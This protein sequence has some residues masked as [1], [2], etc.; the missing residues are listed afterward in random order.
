[1]CYFPDY[2]LVRNATAAQEQQLN[3]S[4][5]ASGTYILTSHPSRC[6][7]LGILVDSCFEQRI[8]PGRSDFANRYR[9]FVHQ[10]RD[11]SMSQYEII[12]SRATISSNENVN[13]TCD[14]S[15]AKWIVEKGDNIAV[16][17]NACDDNYNNCPAHGIFDSLQLSTNTTVQ[18]SRDIN[19]R[20]E[21]VDQDT[22]TPLTPALV[23]VRVQVGK[24]QLRYC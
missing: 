23:N 7:G 20:S 1:M 11:N 3:T 16:E 14:T 6:A 9:L 12:D 21:T 15:P 17:I 18:Y 2:N 10:Y 5:Y 24:K 4:G 19:S 13:F 8:E 22:L